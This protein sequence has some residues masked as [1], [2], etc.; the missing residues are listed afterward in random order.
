MVTTQYNVLMGPRCEQSG[1]DSRTIEDVKMDVLAGNI[2]YEAIMGEIVPVYDYDEWV[3]EGVA[4]E[5]AHDA[6]LSRGTAELRKLWGDDARI[7]T[8]SS[9]GQKAKGD[10]LGPFVSLRF[11]V[12]GVG[13]FS[14][15]ADMKL[16]GYVPE[17]FDQSVYKAAG[18]RQLMRLWGASKY[19]ESRPMLMLLGGVFRKLQDVNNEQPIIATHFLEEGL[20]QNV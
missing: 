2:V 18:K 4:L 17:M 19:G 5:A 1:F 20:A 7:L 15:G 8:Y 11:I 13:K 16:G 6:T 14:S 9:S 12:R 10:K 3:P